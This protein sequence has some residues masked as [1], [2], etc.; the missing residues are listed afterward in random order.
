MGLVFHLVRRIFYVEQK[1]SYSV[2]GDDLSSYAFLETKLLQLSALDL[3]YSVVKFQ[4]L[5]ECS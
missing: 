4:N 5:G 1:D 2:R 3:M